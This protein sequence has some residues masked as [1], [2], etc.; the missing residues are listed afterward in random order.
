[1]SSNESVILA[2]AIWR[3]IANHK[4]ECCGWSVMDAKHR[5]IQ[6]LG[7]LSALAGYGLALLLIRGI[8]LGITRGFGTTPRQAFWVA[9]GYL[10]FF[11]L[12]A[13]LII[14]G[15]H[16]LAKAHGNSLSEARFG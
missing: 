4:L 2:A 11:S 14:V 15:R 13:Y 10:I 12:A 3:F 1:E 8:Y 6:M 9:L 7:W 16:T 5:W